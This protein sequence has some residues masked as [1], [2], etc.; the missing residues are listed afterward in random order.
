MFAT[1]NP[2]SGFFK[3]KR[4]SLNSVL[5]ARFNPVVFKE[6]PFKDWE[7][8]IDTRLEEKGIND[9]K[10]A[11]TIVKWHFTFNSTLKNTTSPTQEQFPEV[12]AY[13]QTSLRD[14]LKLIDFI[15]YMRRDGRWESK[16][17][18]WRYSLAEA[19]WIV[20]VARMHKAKS[21]DILRRK[22][23]ECLEIEE[24]NFTSD[25]P[26][27]DTSGSTNHNFS[28]CGSSGKRIFGTD[29]SVA[30]ISND[31]L[32]RDTINTYKSIL[33][34]LIRGTELQSEDQLV[35]KL[36]TAHVQIINLIFSDDFIKVHGICDISDVTL[37]AW[38]KSI[39]CK[40]N[41]NIVE[42]AKIGARYYCDQQR[43]LS[44]QEKICNIIAE[45]I[46][47]EVRLSTQDLLSTLKGVPHLFSINIWFLS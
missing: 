26:P 29:S 40:A 23:V 18:G 36:I 14:A 3:D 35:V 31:K 27:V 39:C 12:T 33:S 4:E 6:L 38:F 24:H 15:A 37:K 21:R 28:I 2:N 44:A 7:K 30:V 25:Y 47:T 19:A 1:Q 11:E 17:G 32:S 43:H 10:V 42:A 20:Y 46:A 22:L 34:G 45:S 8:I 9:Q 16:D 13:T 5:L 41:I